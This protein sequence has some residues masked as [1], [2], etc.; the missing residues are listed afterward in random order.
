M[1]QLSTDFDAHEDSLWEQLEPLIRTELKGDR[2]WVHDRLI[3]SEG[4]W[5]VA[6]DCHEHAGYRSTSKYT[7]LHAPY[8][9]ENPF[10]FLIRHE[11]LSDRLGKLLGEQDVQTGE[12]DLDH[13]FLMQATG[14]KRL[15]TILTRPRLRELLRAEP[16]VVIVLHDDHGYWRDHYETTTR[17]VTIEVHGH[18]KDVERLQ[19][20]FHILAE[21][22][23]GLC[24][25][26]GQ[27]H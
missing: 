2:D 1:S 26:R 20:L 17:D 18:E 22:M 27:T 24:S 11:S 8:V 5:K 15:R 9:S 12:A 7:R 10:A 6:L 3:V 19:R 23:S 14:E 4:E 16:E 25:T 13:S 21:I